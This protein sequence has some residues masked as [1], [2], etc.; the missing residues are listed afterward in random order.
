MTKGILRNLHIVITFLI[1]Y[2]ITNKTLK[3]FDITK[4]IITQ[5]TF[6]QL[7]KLLLQKPWPPNQ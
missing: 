4:V 3:A 1:H 7:R 2:Q 5:S 6:F